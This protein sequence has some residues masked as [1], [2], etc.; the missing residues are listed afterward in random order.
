MVICFAI[1]EYWCLLLEEQG[2]MPSRQ[3]VALCMYIMYGN[4]N[5]K[6]EEIMKPLTSY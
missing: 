5:G 1:F 4:M 6:W 2:N 3:K